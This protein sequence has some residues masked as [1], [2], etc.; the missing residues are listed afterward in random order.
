MHVIA[1][2]VIAAYYQL[3]FDDTLQLFHLENLRLSN[4]WQVFLPKVN[5]C[6]LADQFLT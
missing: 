3:H 2:D 5:W 4:I 1:G 6:L